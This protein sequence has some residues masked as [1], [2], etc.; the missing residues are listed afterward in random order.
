MVIQL[1]QRILASYMQRINDYVD[2]VLQDSHESRS[3]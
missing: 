1:F 3:E 2:K